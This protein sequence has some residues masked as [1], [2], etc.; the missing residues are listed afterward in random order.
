MSDAW[1]PRAQAYRD[2]PTHA[3]DA[4]LDIVVEMCNPH[5]G[6]KILDVATGGGHVAR[7]LREH[8]AEVVTLDPAPGM[9]ADVVAPAEQIPF[10]D[11][12]FDVVVTRIAPHHFAGIG[13]AV[14][15]MARV[16]NRKL[17]VE[18]TLYTSEEVEAAE[19]LRDP[20]HVRNYSEEEWRELIE[21]AAFEVERVEFF[22]KTHVLD[23][24][25]ARTGCAGDEAERVRGLLRDVTAPDGATW[26]DT[27]IIFSARRSQS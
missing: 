16:A 5:A 3:A 19:K 9:G 20:T 12:S 4:D 13:T 14:G 17:V 7:R 6:V 25:L 1:S 18:D 23:E 2:S 26:H 10:A 8:G 11:G 22:E 24:W 15:E 27:K 21:S